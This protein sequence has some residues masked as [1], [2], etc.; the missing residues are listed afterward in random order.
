MEKRLILGM[1]VLAILAI[2][3]WIYTG[4]LGFGTNALGSITPPVQNSKSAVGAAVK[5]FN[6][7]AFRFGYEPDK[8][9]VNKG[10]KVKIIINNTDTL[11]GI[12][13]PDLNIKGNEVIE[14][15]TNQSGEFI[16]YCNVMCGSGHST[17][18]GTLT[19]K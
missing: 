7:T 8:I 14:F 18:K 15:T 17:M 2:G 4:F 1:A 16:W 6:V 5:E 12:R 9:T 10:D 13:I 3:I 19:I 11:H